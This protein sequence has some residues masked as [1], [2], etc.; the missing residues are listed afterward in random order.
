[1]A[2]DKSKSKATD[3]RL[4]IGSI[5]AQLAADVASLEARL[6]K[7]G[8]IT[9]PL[10]LHQKPTAEDF[11][12]YVTVRVTAEALGSLKKALNGVKFK[13]SVLSVAPARPDWRERWAEDHKRQAGPAPLTPEQAKR[14]YEPAKREIDVIPGRMRTA[15]RRYRGDKRMTVRILFGD[16]VKKIAYLPKKKLWGMMKGRELQHL[17]SGYAHGK[18][19]DGNGDVVEVVDFSVK[20]F[21]IKKA[22]TDGKGIPSRAAAGGAVAGAAQGQGDDED[23]D[24]ELKEERERNL[25]ILQGMFDGADDGDLPRPM[26]LSDDEEDEGKARDSDSDEDDMDWDNLT[27]KQTKIIADADF[28]DPEP[29]VN[30]NNKNYNN[31]TST[32]VQAEHEQEKEEDSGVNSTT[33]LRSLFNPTEDSGTFSLFGDGFGAGDEDDIQEE[34]VMHDPIETPAVVIE[35]PKP[36]AKSHTDATNDSVS[37]VPIYA[38]ATRGLFFPHFDSPYLNSQSQL[39]SLTKYTLDNEEWHKKFYEMRGEWNRTFR[40]RRRDV[41]KQI[42]RSNKAKRRT[43]AI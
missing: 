25:N 15:P 38:Q 13:G 6:A 3:M 20:P 40:R 10:E 16:R 17:V 18:W 28:A 5:S 33:K 4:H 2:K 43:V 32:A 41:V 11:F 42:H 19:T 12:A 22:S 24:D 26:K 29:A 9:K 31:K 35:V 30:H 21:G 27:K 37:G 39:A 34:V 23:E 1:M 36:K 8:E 14:L 7:F